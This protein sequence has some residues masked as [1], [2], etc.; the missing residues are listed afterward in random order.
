MNASWLEAGDENG[1]VFL[2]SNNDQIFRSKLY[3]SQ[4]VSVPSKMGLIIDEIDNQKG[5]SCI[6]WQFGLCC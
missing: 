2:Q 3:F 6:G 1:V 5:E 4:L